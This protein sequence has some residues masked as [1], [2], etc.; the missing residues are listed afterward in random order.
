MLERPQLLFN[1][2][3]KFQI[4][5]NKEQPEYWD[6]FEGIFVGYGTRND[7][8]CMFKDNKDK[9]RIFHYFGITKPE[10]ISNG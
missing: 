10:L 9:I 2:K 5:W 1:F 7:S 3:Y 6:D 4:M 8:H